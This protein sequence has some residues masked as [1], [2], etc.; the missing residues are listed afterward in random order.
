MLHN[1]IIRLILSSDGINISIFFVLRFTHSHH[2][3]RG[4]EYEL[5]STDKEVGELAQTQTVDRRQSRDLSLS[6]FSREDFQQTLLE[7]NV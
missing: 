5:H 7:G 3:L 1:I 2:D 6:S 4:K